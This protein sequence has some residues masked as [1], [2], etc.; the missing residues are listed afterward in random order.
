VK[1]FL[2]VVSI[3]LRVNKKAVIRRPEVMAD[4]FL[5][6]FLTWLQYTSNQSTNTCNINK[7]PKPV[8]G[9]GLSSNPACSYSSW[10][11][12]IVPSWV[13][14]FPF[15]TAP[16]SFSERESISS[17]NRFIRALASRMAFLLSCSSSSRFFSFLCY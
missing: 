16:E 1:S 13:K 17:A 4:G 6:L 10:A 12:F 15:P 7:D 3:P 8:K 11:S 2:I 14:E 9:S 5:A